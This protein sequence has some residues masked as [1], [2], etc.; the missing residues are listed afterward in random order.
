MASARRPVASSG[1]VCLSEKAS[2]WQSMQGH[3]LDYPLPRQTGLG[4]AGLSRTADLVSQGSCTLR[5]LH[6]ERVRCPQ[7]LPLAVPVQAGVE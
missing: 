5:R 3:S 7:L 6:W 1:F 2:G 4:W